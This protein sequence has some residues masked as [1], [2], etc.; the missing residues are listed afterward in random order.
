M[1]DRTLPYIP[2]LMIKSDMDTVPDYPLPEEY[3][4]V[5]MQDAGFIQAWD[6]IQIDSEQM[7][8]RE[9]LKGLFLREFGDR[10]EDWKDRI[11][12]VRHKETNALIATASLWF[13]N[14]FGYEMNRIHWVATHKAHQNKG[15]ARAM[16]SRLLKVY[17]ELGQTGGVYLFTQTFSY[18]AIGVYERM[19]FAPYLGEKPVN[20]QLEDYENKNPLAWRLIYEKLNAFRSRQKT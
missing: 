1:I 7:E 13:G 17:N 16:L 5:F 19:G 10:P 20:W 14:P 18:A 6:D 9:T 15:I 2:V 4:F 3:E 11:L 12:F 8:N